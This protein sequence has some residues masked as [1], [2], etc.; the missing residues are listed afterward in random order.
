M[1]NLFSLI[2]RFF[3]AKVVKCRLKAWF[4]WEATADTFAISRLILHSAPVSLRKGGCG[5]KKKKQIDNR[6][7]YRFSHIIPFYLLQPWQT[8]VCIRAIPNRAVT[9]F[10][11]LLFT[12]FYSL[13]HF[14]F[15]FSYSFDAVTIF[16]FFH[17][18]VFRLV[19]N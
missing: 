15:L 10:F 3:V 1:S 19:G 8:I 11:L 18:L 17:P 9:C 14:F 4:D 12:F 16:S 6:A 7:R 5:C 2:R 13:S